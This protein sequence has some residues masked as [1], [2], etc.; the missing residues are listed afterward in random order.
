MWC[1][2]KSFEEP[3][4]TDR[5][6][7]NERFF[8]SELS[9]G[10]LPAQRGHEGAEEREP[11][12]GDPHQACLDHAR[13]ALASTGWQIDAVADHGRSSRTVASCSRWRASSQS[14]VQ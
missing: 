11:A 12:G 8:R 1:G 6:A 4:G 9:R 3:E 2:A 14:P 5:V 7:R 13:A 10:A